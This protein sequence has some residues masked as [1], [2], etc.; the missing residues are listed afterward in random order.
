MLSTT[1]L[2][3]APDDLGTPTVVT[4]WLVAIGADIPADTPLVRL[5]V[6]GET[7]MVLTPMAGVLI[8]HC[9]AIG[10]PLAPNDL[11]AMIE[12]EEPSFGISLLPADEMD[13]NLSVPACRLG[14]ALPPVSNYDDDALLLCAELG[15]APDEVICSGDSLSRQDVVCHVRRQ[16]RTLASVQQL[17]GE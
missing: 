15:V 1:H 17:L 2:V 16:L 5:A 3:C 12:A 6:A 13:D 7:H 8:E 11:L 9:V 4:E 14:R 10:E